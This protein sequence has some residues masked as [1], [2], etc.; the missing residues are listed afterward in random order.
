M[1]IWRMWATLCE[2]VR[3]DLSYWREPYSYVLSL[4]LW[5]CAILAEIERIES[6]KVDGDMGGGMRGVFLKNQPF[7]CSKRGKWKYGVYA[8]RPDESAVFGSDSIESDMQAILIKSC[9]FTLIYFRL[10][11]YHKGKIVTPIRPVP[12]TVSFNYYRKR[13]VS[14]P[15]TPRDISPKR[16]SIRGRY[17]I[18][19]A[20]INF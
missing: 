6:E 13:E 19:R 14:P 3:L 20:L 8:R 1:P 2:H 7:R 9:I 16:P 5:K 12:R 4:A 15:Q 17:L 11:P 10:Q 18:G